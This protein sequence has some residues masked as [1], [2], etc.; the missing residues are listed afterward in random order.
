LRA[1][2]EAVETAELAHAK[3]LE[4]E[5]RAANMFAAAE[6]DVKSFDSLDSD[7]TAQHAGKLRIAIVKGAPSPA[8][9]ALPEH[10]TEAKAKRSA[11]FEK[12]NAIRDVHAE[13][14]SDLHTSAKAVDLAKYHL[15][16]A[17]E[18]VVGEDAKELADKWLADLADLQKRF[19]L[20]DAINGRRIR[21]HPDEPKQHFGTGNRPLKLDAS[22]HKIA[23]NSRGVLTDDAAAGAIAEQ[24]AKAVLVGELVQTL[25]KDADAKL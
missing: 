1:A 16:L 18:S 8:L 5:A 15:D 17:V 24:Q 6:T 7:I 11:A 10:L 9:G 12:L 2:I 4:A 25:H 22:I 3:S 19:W 21:N 14:S 23:I 13:L 20:F